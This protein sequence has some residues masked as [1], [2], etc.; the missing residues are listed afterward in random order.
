MGWKSRWNITKTREI[1]AIE[2][3]HSGIIE[4]LSREGVGNIAVVSGQNEGGTDE[5]QER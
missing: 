3:Y 4:G 1:E 5:E 2:L